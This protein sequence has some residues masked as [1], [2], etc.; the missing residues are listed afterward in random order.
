MNTETNQH[1]CWQ[2]LYKG[3]MS[4]NGQVTILDED[5]IA[6]SVLSESK[7]AKAI[8]TISKALLQEFV[9]Y[10]E[11]HPD[12]KADEAR[13]NLKGRSD[14][15]KFEYGYAAT[16]M[17]MAEMVLRKGKT[18]IHLTTPIQHPSLPHQL[19]FYGAPGTGKSFT[20]KDRTRGKM[21]I[22]TTF[23]PDSDYSTFV[24]TYKPIT[25]EVPRYT[26]LGDKALELKD[27]SGRPVMES[28]I[29]YEFVEQAFLKAYVNAWREFCMGSDARDQFLIIEEINRGNCAQIF[30]DLF[31]LLDRNEWGFSDYPISPD[32]DLQRHVRESLAGLEIPDTR[33]LTSLYGEDVAERVLQGE[34]LIL[35]PNLYLWATMNTSDQSLFPIDSAFKRRWEWQYVPITKGHDPEGNELEWYIEAAG[36]RYS[37]WSF[38]EKI[39]AHIAQL[40]NSEDKKLGFF[41]CKAV[42]G[43]IPATRFVGK[44]LFYLWN[45]VFKDYDFADTIFRDEEGN[46]LSFDK[47]Y[48]ADPHGNAIVREEQVERFLQSLGVELA[49]DAQEARRDTADADER[50]HKET[51]VA[52]T[53]NGE[54]LTADE[55]TQFDL[56]LN[57]LRRLGIATVA[58]VIENMKYR[59]KGSPMAVRTP[60]QTIVESEGYSYVEAEGYYFV[61]GANGYTLVRILENL[62]DILGLDIKI[63]FS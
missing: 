22:R 20:I 51:L 2:K 12:C 35:P 34:L 19:I 13:N 18:S 24:G 38:L 3:D 7:G 48:L 37:W 29:E 30:G 61:K 62:R 10:L 41:F 21:V 54:R 17:C 55:R 53:I 57:V 14:I 45:D 28:R 39:N 25:H 6:Y 32:R 33:L 52:V 15:D 23:H 58:P 40:T 11:T 5:R 49:A 8:R 63:E 44:V 59:R 27:G 31:Q 4:D 9:D 46:A 36:R 1:T 50:D 60:L 26:S 43:V 56:Y 16:L 42:D 47:F